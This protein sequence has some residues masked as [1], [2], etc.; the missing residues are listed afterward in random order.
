MLL[1]WYSD[2]NNVRGLDY[3]HR[4]NLLTPTGS[5]M[6]VA[7][8]TIDGKDKTTYFGFIQC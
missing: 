8:S 7:I 2:Y 6:G 1:G 3:G 5:K 4:Q